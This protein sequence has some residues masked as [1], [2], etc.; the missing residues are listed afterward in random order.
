[1]IGETLSHYRIL[2]QLGSG[3][4]G[5][6][7]RAEDL[8][9]GRSVALKTLRGE[10]G[11]DGMRRLLAEA[12]AASA[13]NHPN[14]AVVYETSEAEYEGRRIGY[15]AMEYVDGATVAS[16]L[17][18]GPLDLDQ[19]L[20]IVEQ[21]ADALTEAH[22]LG[23]VHRDIKPS[24]L[25]VTPA[26]RVKVLDFGVAQRR[27]RHVAGPD[28]VTRLTESFESVSGL[29]GTLPYMAPEQAT[30]REVDGRADIFSLGVV[31]Y[32]LASGTPPFT[33]RNAAQLL[34]AILQQE[35][36]PFPSPERDPRLPSIERLVRRMLERDPDR[37]FA[38]FADVR[39]AIAA[40]RLGRAVSDAI[41][42]PGDSNSVA[43]AGFVNISG[44]PE[45]DWLGAGISET[46]TADAGQLEG[47]SVI[48][49]D[50]VAAILKTLGEQ[51]GDRDEQLFLR[52]GR[53]LRARWIVSG[54]F[55]RSADAV[56]VTASIIEVAGGQLAGTT[57]VDGSLHTIF[58]LQD[59]LV[60]ELARL[61]RAAVTPAAG[62]AQETD[63]VDAYEAFSRGLLN[64][65]AET[66]ESLD[67]AVWLF[68]R[69]VS[70]DPAYAR[71]HVELGAAYATKAD[72]LSMPELYERAA[73]SFR[74][75]IELQP[76][77]AR[78]W[79]ELGSVLVNSG[80]EAEGMPAIR[81]ALAID[82]EDASALG[83]MGRALFIGQARFHEAADWFERA[84]DR[85]ANG[86]WYALQLA[87]CAALIRDF[88]R[89]ERAA[90]RA[91]DLQEAF[92]SGREGL[93][94]AG[95]YIRAGHL[96]ALQGRHRQALEHFERE[97]DFLARTEHTLRHRILVELDTRLGQAY[98][99]LGETRK[100]QAAFTV[101]LES[102]DRRVRL[103]AD[104][105]FTRYYAAAVHALRGDAEPA[106]AF[107]ERAM[108]TH[109]TF[110]TARAR[111]EPEFDGL[112]ADPRFK[113]L[114][115]EA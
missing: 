81:R 31:I 71:A 34:Q 53:E 92:L 60:R 73:A 88:A 63:V 6:V 109:R 72:A 50:R 18:R 86:G 76:A 15:I 9:L 95:S 112:R 24:N 94:I 80:K 110:T 70:L 11:E 66:F 87:H 103:G 10:V 22:K 89:G 7:Y 3:G 52:A 93:F 111:I 75:A 113:K 37:R 38:S 21:T 47:V 84:L 5:D 58:D 114:I 102:F 83:T 62:A 23:L 17:R 56:R 108:A 78:A 115:G 39:D 1:M 96:A 101:A 90:R 85:N 107:L 67:R 104:D 8:L 48:S 106:L 97:I 35:V 30:G 45:D 20:D 4:M 14:I 12:R 13:L 25:M 43:V 19:A 28:D 69:A 82:P 105:P 46:L 100:A 74:R 41:E 51:T 26:G 55:Q 99:Q 64:R 59:R 29:V 27:E 54:G 68:E 77:L 33:G 98:V 32:E 36:P 65:R 57:K 49:R 61:L 40:I 2:E 42:L 79:R 44:N 16:L 91:M